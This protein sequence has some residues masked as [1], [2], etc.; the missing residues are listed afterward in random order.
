MNEMRI[1]TFGELS[2]EQILHL[3]RGYLTGFYY[4]LDDDWEKYKDDDELV[5]GLVTDDELEEAFHG[6]YFTEGEDGQIEDIF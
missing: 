6:C 5:D 2:R 4:E 1:M 3:K